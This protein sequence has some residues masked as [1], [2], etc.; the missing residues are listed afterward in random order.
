MRRRLERQRH[1]AVTAERTAR[2]ERGAETERRERQ[3][4]LLLR[5]VRAQQ[6][7]WP[8]P[9]RPLQLAMHADALRYKQG[10]K[11]IA[12]PLRHVTHVN[13][14]DNDRYLPPSTPPLPPTPPAPRPTTCYSLYS[15]LTA[16]HSPLTTHHSPLTTHQ[17][18]VKIFR[19]AGTVTDGDPAHEIDISTALTHPNVIRVL[20]ALPAPQPKPEPNPDPDHS[21]FD[22]PIYLD[23]LV[24]QA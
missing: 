7:L 4:Q 16:H 18:A 14:V 8:H 11:E 21:F 13:V 23:D 12:I 19:D 20:G 17:V 22:N 3:A 6:P 24:D 2:A 10:K 9:W 1:D 5:P 15:L